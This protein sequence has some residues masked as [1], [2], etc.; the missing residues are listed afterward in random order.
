MLAPCQAMA[1]CNTPCKPRTLNAGQAVDAAANQTDRL[2]AASDA[3]GAQVPTAGR[4][5]DVPPNKAPQAGRRT[6]RRRCVPARLSG[7]ADNRL[8]NVVITLD[9]VKM[10]LGK[11]GQVQGPPLRMLSDAEVAEHLWTGEK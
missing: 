1:S 11:P 6:Q 4:Q 3:W 7:V 5:T 10:I 9:K 2:S 8:Q